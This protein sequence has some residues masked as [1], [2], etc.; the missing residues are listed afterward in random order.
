M[1]F[2]Q[3]GVAGRTGPWG[4]A[5]GYGD[6]GLRPNESRRCESA[7]RVAAPGAGC[8]WR[9]ASALFAGACISHNQEPPERES[10]SLDYHYAKRAAAKIRVAT[11][12]LDGTRYVDRLFACQSAP[13]CLHCWASAVRNGSPQCGQGAGFFLG[14]SHHCGSKSRTSRRKP[15]ARSIMYDETTLTPSLGTIPQFVS[16]D[17]VKYRRAAKATTAN[18]HRKRPT[19][20]SPINTP[21]PAIIGLFELDFFGISTRLPT[22][23]GSTRYRQGSQSPFILTLPGSRGNSF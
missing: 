13:Q 4:V 11:R 9:V 20:P 16:S 8:H 22:S 7:P 10:A 19:T 18:A 3:T 23:V 15:R 6:N 1:A 21:N 12:M 5:P 2:G 14:S 17:K